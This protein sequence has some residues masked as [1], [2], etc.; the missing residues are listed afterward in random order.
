MACCRLERLLSVA[1]EW[2]STKVYV[3][4]SRWVQPAAV[5]IDCHLIGVAVARAPALQLV[6][7]DWLISHYLIGQ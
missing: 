6:V 3:V 4:A 2:V 5:G 7:P 1:E